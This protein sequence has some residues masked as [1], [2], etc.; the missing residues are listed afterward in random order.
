MEIISDIQEMKKVVQALKKEGRKIALVPTM[1]YLHEGHLTLMREG[2]K[3]ADVLVISIF[4]NPT[5][6]GPQEDFQRYPRDIERDQKLA[7]QVGVDII[8]Y[9][10][11]ESMYPSGYRTYVEVAEWGKLLCGASRPIHFRGVCTVVLKLF[12][13]IQPDVAIFG[14]KDAQQFLILRRMVKD[15]N[16][17]VQ[18]VGVETVREPDGL[19]MSSR[20]EYLSPAERRQA[21]ALYQSL[22]RAKELVEQGE[23]DCQKIIAEMKKIIET[24]PSAKID[25]ISIVSLDELKPLSEIQ[26]DNTLIAMAVF[27]GS[28][29]LID[30]IRL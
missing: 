8:F 28:A 14:W 6:F 9:S 3:L 16:L 2:R 12:N 7:E 25:Y 10:S 21:T 22:C 30:N 26:P 4:V 5:Q 18:M 15:L 27:V 17:D 1:G 20:N 11:A 13:I 23:K 29:R 19:A 24:Q